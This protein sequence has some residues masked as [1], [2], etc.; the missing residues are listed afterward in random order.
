MEE[1]KP[2]TYEPPKKSKLPLILLGLV[3]LIGVGAGCYYLGTKT[4]NKEETKS[5]EK[6]EE[7]KDI[8]GTDTNT[9]G[10]KI[11]D[12][13]NK[14]I[15]LNDK[16]Y[17]IKVEILESKELNENDNTELT[18]YYQ[19]VYFNGYKIIDNKDI[20]YSYVYPEDESLE[21]IQKI[22][23]KEMNQSKVLKDTK[24]TEQYFIY[25]TAINE[26]GIF[27]GT[28]IVDK[29]GNILKELNGGL[30]N[31]WIETKNKPNDYH[32]YDESNGIYSIYMDNWVQANDD[33]IV[34]LDKDL[35]VEVARRIDDN[36]PLKLQEKKLVIE[37][38]KVVITDG[39]LFK[40]EE[41]YE[42]TGAG[43]LPT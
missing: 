42:F 9:S 5:E 1:E 36:V 29:K 16:E 22:V 20:Y 30:G 6:T 23:E 35:I 33:F 38:G 43:Q 28:L 37:N 13:K 40:T 31:F 34:Y 3:L 11:V 4:D 24:S 18:N 27:G 19:N 41:G 32:K 39:F 21:K 7:S 2:V 12:T 8:K 15:T 26:Y 10:K 14:N 25:D 17:E